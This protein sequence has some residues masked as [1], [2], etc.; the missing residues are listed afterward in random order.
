MS[1][2]NMK[3][4]TTIL[5]LVS[6]GFCGKL[7]IQWETIDVVIPQDT[8]I[9]AADTTYDETNWDDDYDGCDAFLRDLYQWGTYQAKQHVTHWYIRTEAEIIRKTLK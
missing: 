3:T 7:D 1:N 4:I 2:K 9:T 5:T 8:T 6:I